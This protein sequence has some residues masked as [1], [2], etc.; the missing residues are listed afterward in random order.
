[1]TLVKSTLLLEEFFINSKEVKISNFGL[2]Y[3]HESEGSHLVSLI[4][5][6]FLID[7]YICDIKKNKLKS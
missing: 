6:Y 2:F 5:K 1:M 7:K 4:C 3:K